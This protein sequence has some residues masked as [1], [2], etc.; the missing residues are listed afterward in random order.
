MCTT[1]LVGPEEVAGNVNFVLFYTSSPYTLDHRTIDYLSGYTTCVRVFCFS[2][3][4]DPVTTEATCSV[5]CSVP[6]VRY[7]TFDPL[8]DVVCEDVYS[9]VGLCPCRSTSR[10][11]S[12]TTRLLRR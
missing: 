10:Y 3:L 9:R 2:V 4:C 6:L 1:C 11:Y 8:F 7:D 12:L 5:L